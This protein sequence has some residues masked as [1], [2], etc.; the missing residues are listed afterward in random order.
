MRLRM[1]TYDLAREQC[2]TLDFMRRLCRLSLDSGYNALGLYMESRFAFECTPWAHGQG[3]LTPDTV[4]AIQHEFADLQIVPFLNVLGHCEA[5]IYTEVGKRYAEQTFKGMQACP[6]N[7]AFQSLAIR[8]LDEAMAVFASPLVHVGG[9]EARQLGACPECA[10]RVAEFERG[11]GVDGEARLFGLYMGDL[12]RHVLQAGRTPAIWSDMLI[13][14]PQAADFLPKETTIFHWKYF[15]GPGGA[16]A[17]ARRFPVVYCPTLHTYNA[18]WLHVPQAERALQ[19]HIEA[20][21]EAGAIDGVRSRLYGTAEGPGVLGVCLT[22]W[23]CALMGNYETLLPAIQAAG[24]LLEAGP[25]SQLPSTGGSGS[26]AQSLV[27]SFISAADEVGASEA[28]LVPED[29][30]YLFEAENPTGLSVSIPLPREQGEAV[31]RALRAEAG[32]F[33]GSHLAQEGK[34]REYRLESIPSDSGLEI[35]L[36]REPVPMQREELLEWSD[37]FL[38]GYAAHSSDH[39]RWAEL[40]GVELQTLGGVFAFSGKRSSLKCRLLLY[41]NP[42]LA[43]RHHAAEL[44]GEIGERALQIA[45]Q[46]ISCAPSASYRGVALFVQKAVEFVRFAEQARQAYAQQ[47][48]G[49]SVSCLAPCRQIFDEL[50]KAARASHINACGSLADIERCRVA[51]EHVERVIRRVKEFGDGSLGYLPAFEILTHPKFMPHDQGCW[52]L[53]NE[54]ANE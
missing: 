1:W 41:G 46:A 48:P 31:A 44:S 12:T 7:P 40:M 10:A 16:E 35:V 3:G 54:W 36:R 27:D 20:A 47:L 29:D 38:G 51:K 50:E 52:W 18:A 24:R 14:H 25:K 8:M 9:D 2:P 21:E 5:L 45:D 6:S 28:T 11:D 42:F 34:L 17:L 37:S 49:I 15:S 23:E 43:W 53:I 39:R 19:S 22:T 13:E 4:R 26:A 32:L 33:E 30:G